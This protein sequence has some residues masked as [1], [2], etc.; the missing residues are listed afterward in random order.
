VRVRAIAAIVL[1]FALAL[2]ASRAGAGAPAVVV[3]GTPNARYALLDARIASY[4]QTNAVP[5]AEFAVSVRGKVVFSHAYTNSAF[6]SE[7]ITTKTIFRLASNSKAWTCAAISQLIA[8]GALTG[9]EP[10]FAYL[11]I[12]DPLP[13]GASIADPRVFSITVRELVDHRGGWDRSVAHFDPVHAMRRIAIDAGLNHPVSAVDVARYMLGQPL[14]HA[15]GTAYAYSNFGY[16]LLGLVIEKAS[17]EPYLTYVQTR[18]AQPL[19]VSDLVLS[20]TED[21]RLPGEVVYASSERGLS[22]LHL[23]DTQ[24]VPGYAGGDGEIREVSIAAGGLATSAESM[25]ALMSAH[26]IWGLGSPPASGSSARE[27]AADGSNTFAKQR[28]DGIDYAILVNRRN[29]EA[30]RALQSQL[31]RDLDA[32]R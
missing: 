15:P 8:D 23:A 28:A 21:P 29:E 3:S 14:Q 5:N 22:P 26:A 11:G 10:V 19:G 32:T 25:L 1:A 24:P 2:V 9:S 6:S 27:G 16:L 7:P 18:V 20:P 4:L 13:A 31:D 12:H 17:G 30:F